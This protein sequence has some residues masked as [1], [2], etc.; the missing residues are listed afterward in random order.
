[1]PLPT[2]PTAREFAESAARVLIEHG[3]DLGW[4]VV[5]PAIQSDAEFGMAVVESTFG[6][7]AGRLPQLAE[8][9]VADLYIWL[10]QQYP[11]GD[12]RKTGGAVGRRD[13]S[14]FRDGLITHLSQRGTYASCA[15]I[16][17]IIGVFPDFT[18]LKWHLQRARETARRK[19]WTPPRV[20]DLIALAQEQERR[21]VQNGDQLLQVVIESLQRLDAKLQGETPA[22]TFLWNEQKGGKYRPKDENEVSDFV[23]LHLEDDLKRRGIIVNREVQIRQGYKPGTGERT[24]L[25]VDGVAFGPN[26]KV[27]DIVT[28]IIETK[29]C[30]HAKL[31]SAME[32]QLKDRYLKDNKCDH[33]IYLVGWFNCPQWDI[34]NSSKPPSGTREEARKRFDDQATAL[35]RNGITIR[36]FLLNT[37]LRS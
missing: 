20:Q 19:T 36:A 35:S 26:G 37:S 28:V 3:D 27:L 2:D 6:G 21:F 23:K 22:A 16:E 25:H 33:G 4:S 18:W 1:L 30:W 11:Y 13:T 5:W 9:Q 12:D 17:K 8:D 10:V 32:T 31:N 7:I 34:S 14:H 15:G 29:G 24:D